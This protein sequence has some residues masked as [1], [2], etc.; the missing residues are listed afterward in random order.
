MRFTNTKS[1]PVGIVPIWREA[2]DEKDDYIAL[3]LKE[4]AHLGQTLCYGPKEAP[5]AA[6]TLFPLYLQ[7]GGIIYSGYYLYALGVLQRHRGKGYGSLLVRRAHEYARQNKGAFILLQP[8]HTSLFDYYLKLGYTYA[9]SRSFLRC[10]RATLQNAGPDLFCLLAS[11]SAPDANRFIWSE[12]MRQ[13]ILKEC[14]FRGGALIAQTAYCYP[15]QDQ[16]GIFV[17]IKEFKSSDSEI[18]LL[19]RGLLDHLPQA[20]Y[21]VFYGKADNTPPHQRQQTSFA[22]L[23]F[24]ESE[25]ETL[26]HFNLPAYFALGLD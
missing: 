26:Y 16:S 9:V 23:H 8:T 4:A 18:P 10:S 3:F 21:F 20:D 15:R 14:F 11:R 22:L 13:Y 25:V 6:L 1:S 17:E 5:Y 19:F 2:F 7:F 24:I 12:P